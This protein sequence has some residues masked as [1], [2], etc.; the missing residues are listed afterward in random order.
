MHMQYLVQGRGIAFLRPLPQILLFRALE[1]MY[2]RCQQLDLFLNFAHRRLNVEGPILLGGPTLHQKLAIH[3]TRDQVEGFRTH[4]V[5][6]FGGGK[7]VRGSH[8]HGSLIRDEFGRLIAAGC[9]RFLF[10]AGSG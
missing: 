10:F 2:N 5:V 3:A 9:G 4:K 8:A 1:H 6:E 7:R